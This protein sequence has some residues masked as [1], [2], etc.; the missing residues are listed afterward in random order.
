VVV[1]LWFLEVCF[2]TA[3][4]TKK[5]TESTGKFRLRLLEQDSSYGTEFEV[6]EVPSSLT[7]TF[8]IRMD[9]HFSSLIELVNLAVPAVNITN[10]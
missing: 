9:S 1:K 5:S 2:S 10:S 3:G 6:I 7:V 4:T 8:L